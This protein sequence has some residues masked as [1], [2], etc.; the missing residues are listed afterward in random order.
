M[1]RR[2]HLRLRINMYD[3]DEYTALQK[4]ISTYRDPKAAAEEDGNAE[5]EEK[6][7]KGWQVRRRLR[8]DLARV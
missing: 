6:S 4:Y 8:R 2:R 1:H 5:P 3:L 7:K